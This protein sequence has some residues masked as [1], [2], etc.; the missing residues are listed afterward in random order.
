MDTGIRGRAD[1]WS[2][3]LLIYRF[4]NIDDATVA[5]GVETWRLYDRRIDLTQQ[6]RLIVE[7]ILTYDTCRVSLAT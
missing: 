7:R 6:M 2:V 1:R 5:G 4:D 3:S